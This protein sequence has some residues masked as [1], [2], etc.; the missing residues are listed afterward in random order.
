MKVSKTFSKR[1]LRKHLNE[2]IT[3]AKTVTPEVET[4]VLIPGVE[5]Q[6]AWLEIYV[7]EE[8]FDRVNELISQRVY[9]LFIE[10]G[11]DIGAIVHDKSQLRQAA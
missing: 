11:Y 10:T 9:D 8:L 4:M 6:H 7:A 3:L 1:Q 2:L 5:N